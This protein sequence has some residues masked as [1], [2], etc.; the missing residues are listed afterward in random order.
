MQ[1]VTTTLA[2]EAFA[3][4]RTVCRLR[5]NAS[6]CCRNVALRIK[7]VVTDQ[8]RSPSTKLTLIYRALYRL[9]NE[10]SRRTSG[11]L[12]QYA[13]YDARVDSSISSLFPIWDQFNEDYLR[14]IRPQSVLLKRAEH[15][16]NLLDDILVQM[17][18]IEKQ[19]EMKWLNTKQ[20]YEKKSS[21]RHFVRMFDRNPTTT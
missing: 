19:E 2:P 14:K 3:Q 9:F 12:Q 8:I 4:Y 20:L 1:E 10:N 18:V 13:L 17:V 16:S 11:A 7:R 21:F 6:L 15:I 5:N